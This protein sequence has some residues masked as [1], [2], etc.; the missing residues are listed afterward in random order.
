MKCRAGVVSAV[1]VTASPSSGPRLIDLL[2]DNSW[3]PHLADEFKKPYFHKLEKFIKHEC[4][5]QRVF[6]ASSHIFRYCI[7]FLYVP[8]FG[9]QQSSTNY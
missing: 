5:T 4:N 3:K 9:C 6:P 1:T 7:T 2:E 8:M